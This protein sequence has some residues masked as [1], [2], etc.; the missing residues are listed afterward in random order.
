MQTDLISIESL[1]G[2]LLSHELRMAQTQPKVDLSLAGIINCILLLEQ[3]FHP[4]LQGNHTGIKKHSK[5]L[6]PFYILNFHKPIHFTL[7]DIVLHCLLKT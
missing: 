1:Y 7:L 3:G 4:G 5:T 6:V 2:H